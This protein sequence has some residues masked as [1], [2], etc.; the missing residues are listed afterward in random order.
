[1]EIGVIVFALAV[2]LIRGLSGRRD[3]KAR[4]TVARALNGMPGQREARF[5][6]YPT[7]RFGR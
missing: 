4:S 1:M 3:R 2:G 5:A 7:G 6:R